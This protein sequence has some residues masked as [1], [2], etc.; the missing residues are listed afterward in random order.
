MYHHHTLLD[1]TPKKDQCEG[2][3]FSFHILPSLGEVR[4]SYFN[5]YFHFK[6]GYVWFNCVSI[7]HIH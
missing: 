2:T 7:V 6:S 1:L 3:L 5:T 4:L